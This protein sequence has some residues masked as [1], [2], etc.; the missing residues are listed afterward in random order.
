MRQRKY[1]L[2]LTPGRCVRVIDGGVDVPEVDLAHET[3]NL[4]AAVRK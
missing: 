4:N 3:I 1:M 2:S